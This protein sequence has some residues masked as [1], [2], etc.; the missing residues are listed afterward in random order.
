MR[1]ADMMKP[2][3]RV[4]LKSEWGQI[5][6]EWP[7][8]SFT[9]RSVGDQLRREFV[10]GRDVLV[11][12]GT[13]DPET[14]RLP[15]HRSR[16]IS[17]V[18]IEPNQVL[19]TR[20]IVPL[21]VWTKSNAQWGDRWPYS[22]AVISAANIVGP[23]FPAAH[24][25]IPAAYRS[26]SEIA[27]RGGVVEALESEREAIMSLDIEPMSLDLREDVRAYLEL[28]SSLSPERDSLVKKSV[29]RMAQLIV[30]RVERGG[31]I[32]VKI[33]PIRYAPNLST[34]MCS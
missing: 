19:E 22:M 17:A 24:D 27:N 5:S 18:T 15:E 1:V 33:N 14:T 31:D 32:G 20:K 29:N 6:D 2:G 3:G 26:F 34:C 30:D 21:D 12:V 8:V 10:A 25:V 11:Y 16:L 23:P 13:T 28:R 7:C 9:K 4:F